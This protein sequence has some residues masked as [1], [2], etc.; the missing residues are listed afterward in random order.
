[1]TEYFQHTYLT[2]KGLQRQLLNT[3]VG[4]HDLVCKCN[5]PLTHVAALI[6]EDA[7]PTN[8]TE[9]QKKIIKQCLGEDA[10]T[11]TGEDLAIDGGDLEQLFAEDDD[12]ENT[13]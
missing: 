1:M 6:F 8:F 2:K 12:T 4:N 7:K 3:I 9:K 5:E 11:T 10:G 13:G